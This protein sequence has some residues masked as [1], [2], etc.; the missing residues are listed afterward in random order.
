VAI[1]AVRWKEKDRAIRSVL[2]RH[3]L[4]GEIHTAWM[5][6]RYPEQ[7][8]IAGFERLSTEDRRAA[9]LRERKADLAKASMRG[10]RAVKALAK[11]YRK[12][13]PYVHLTYEERL[14]AI[15]DAAST[16]GQWEEATLFADAQRKSAHRATSPDERILDHGCGAP[17]P[18][19]WHEV[20]GD[21][22]NR[23]DPVVCG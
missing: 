8:R 1:P 12:T 18:P 19:G 11:N 3:N 20:R 21:R 2:D 9:V 15:R 13:E 4:Y 10:Q 23:R 6:R 17:V 22:S 7:Q 14:A 5:V 16:I